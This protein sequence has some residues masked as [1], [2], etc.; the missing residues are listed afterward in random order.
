[1]HQYHIVH[2]YDN[3]CINVIKKSYLCKTNCQ[4]IAP[5]SYLNYAKNAAII[6]RM[7]I[8]M[9]IICIMYARNVHKYAYYMYNVC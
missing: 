2:I 7:C 5:I 8:S 3:K 6:D 1:M 9:H 4:K